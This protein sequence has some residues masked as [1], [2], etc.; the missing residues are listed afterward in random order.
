[1]HKQGSCFYNE[2]S[3]IGLTPAHQSG[4]I[5]GFIFFNGF[6]LKVE[7]VSMCHDSSDMSEQGHPS[8]FN[9]LRPAEVRVM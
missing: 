1:M 7:S 2:F 4:N 6:A 3:F 5:L 8:I 9:F